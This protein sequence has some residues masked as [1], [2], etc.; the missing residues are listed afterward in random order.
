MVTPQRVE[1]SVEAILFPWAEGPL[2]TNFLAHLAVWENFS[3][4]IV[5]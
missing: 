2:G 5:I 1:F 3:I 4:G